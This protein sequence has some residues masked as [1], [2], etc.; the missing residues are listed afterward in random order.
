MHSEIWMGRNARERDTR[1]HNILSATQLERKKKKKE[2]NTL[3]IDYICSS[4]RHN[5]SIRYDRTNYSTSHILSVSMKNSHYEQ[6]WLFRTWINY[7][8]LTIM[9]VM[10]AMPVQDW[11]SSVFIYNYLCRMF[12]IINVYPKYDIHSRGE[13]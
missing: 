1:I 12:V 6:K 7:N 9:S 11:Y 10:Y 4:Y 5:N 3:F 2:V 8:R 13:L